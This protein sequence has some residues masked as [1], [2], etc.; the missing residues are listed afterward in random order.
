MVLHQP[1][2]QRRRWKP[3]RVGKRLTW[4][5]C[6]QACSQPR[7]NSRLAWGMS[8]THEAQ[9]TAH[10]SRSL[11]NGTQVD[12]EV[13]SHTLGV[14]IFTAEIEV[15]WVVFSTFS[16]A[17]SM[18]WIFAYFLGAARGSSSLHPSLM[19]PFSSSGLIY[20]PDF[21]MGFPGSS[22]GKEF[23]SSGDP[24]LIPGSGRSPGEGIGY[25]LQYS[26]AFLVAQM[27]KSPPTMWGTWVWYWVGKI[28][29]R[30]KWQSTPVFLPGE[31]PWT[32]EPG[33]VQSLESQRVGYDW[34]TKHRLPNRP[35]NL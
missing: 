34:V 30:R 7:L 33:G 29:W 13:G 9:V 21:Q 19:Y 28:P 23:T 24:S 27:V 14:D 31:S 4:P 35:P 18:V 16:K 15:L 17:L 25:P 26:W 5:G 20:F 6:A 12:T 10:S 22:A 2:S 3:L 1:L 8:K 11:G 32:E